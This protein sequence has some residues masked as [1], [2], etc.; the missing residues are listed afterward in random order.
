MRQQPGELTVASPTVPSHRSRNFRDERATLSRCTTACGHCN[1]LSY[2]LMLRLLWTWKRLDQARASGA[3]GH[4]P[5]GPTRPVHQRMT[6]PQPGAIGAILLPAR[7]RETSCERS[8]EPAPVSALHRHAT[9]WSLQHP[10]ATSRCQV[11]ALGR[12][13]GRRCCCCSRC[14]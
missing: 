14:C 6:A 12:H 7:I 11:M 2:K 10:A 13:D 9:R 5:S 4:E 1:S 8:H 3:R